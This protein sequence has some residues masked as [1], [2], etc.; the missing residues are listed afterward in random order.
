[1]GKESMASKKVSKS[2]KQT[3]QSKSGLVFP[4]SKVKRLMKAAKV[5]S[6]IQPKAVIYLTAALE[7]IAGE[8]LE[9]SSLK[10]QESKK[11]TISNKH[12]YL[13]AKAD[14]ELDKVALGNGAFIKDAGY[15]SGN[16]LPPKKAKTQKDKN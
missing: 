8:L 2:T 11:G 4:P 15:A 10:A 3:V 16:A 12:I 9:V 7:Y 1:M 14:K 5:A 6:R 13:G